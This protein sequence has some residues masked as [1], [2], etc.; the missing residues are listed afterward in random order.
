MN[1]D[2]YLTQAQQQQIRS[3]IVDRCRRFRMFEKQFDDLF[4]VPYTAMRHK[5]TLTSAVLS[6]F[7]PEV[8]KIEGITSE[9]VYYGLQDKLAQPELRTKNAVFQIYSNG[10]DLKGKLIKARC[11]E[12]NKS[13]S[14]IFFLVV[15]HAA[16]DGELKQIE[17]CFLDSEAQVVERQTIWAATQIKTMAG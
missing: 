15:F 1:I 6:G 11:A 12:F 16:G 5:Q 4:Y 9:T 13:N 2:D 8:L 3:V 14:P 10:S 17:V 7:A